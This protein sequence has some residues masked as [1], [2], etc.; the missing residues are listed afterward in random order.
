MI[1]IGEE[2]GSIPQ[3]LMQSVMRLEESNTS[4]YRT[5][6]KIMVVGVYLTVAL[7]IAITIITFYAGMFNVN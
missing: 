4:R 3:T 2:S 5:L 6:L 7:F 1:A